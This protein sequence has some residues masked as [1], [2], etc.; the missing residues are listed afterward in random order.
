MIH[1]LVVKSNESSIDIDRRCKAC[2]ILHAGVE[3]DFPG[4]QGWSDGRCSVLSWLVLG[5]AT[6]R[7]SREYDLQGH[8]GRNADYGHS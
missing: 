4:R 7:V 3:G 8:Q 1:G 5:E 2:D 6:L